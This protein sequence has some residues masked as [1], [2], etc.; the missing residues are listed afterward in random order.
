MKHM[1]RLQR[2]LSALLLPC[3]LLT[4]TAPAHAAMVGTGE[5]VSLAQGSLEREQLLSMLA[6]EDVRE[7]LTAAGVDPDRAVERVAALSPEE[8]QT[9]SE[10][11]SELPAGGDSLIGAAVFVF[12][13]LLVTDILGFTDVFPFVKKTAR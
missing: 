12:L 5:V 13:V 2:I 3:F 6:R 10:R 1:R 7:K 11:F 4:V 8:L 9:V